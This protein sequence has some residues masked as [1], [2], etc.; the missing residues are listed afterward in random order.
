MNIF[1]FDKMHMLYNQNKS[2]VKS[3][4]KY[5]FKNPLFTKKTHCFPTCALFYPIVLKRKIITD[6]I[7][8]SMSFLF[9]VRHCLTAFFTVT[10]MMVMFSLR[11]FKNDTHC[12]CNLSKTNKKPLRSQFFTILRWKSNTLWSR[13]RFNHFC[14]RYNHKRNNKQCSLSNFNLPFIQISHM[15]ITYSVTSSIKY[16]NENSTHK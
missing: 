11:F 14:W 4:Q 12:L 7:I 15:N 5:C 13:H 10:Q 9:S 2:C 6:N 3:C 1:Y 8:L 16:M